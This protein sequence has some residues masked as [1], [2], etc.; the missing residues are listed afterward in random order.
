[1][2]IRSTLPS[3]ES[4]H[5]MSGSADWEGRLRVVFMGVRLGTTI[6]DTSLLEFKYNLNIPFLRVH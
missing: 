4:S 1:M 3:A 6:E 5:R 2:C